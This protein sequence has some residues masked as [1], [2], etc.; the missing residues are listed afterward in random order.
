MIVAAVKMKGREEKRREILQTIRDITDQVRKS[1][2]CLGADCYQDISDKNVF[3]HVQQWQ[4]RKHLDNHMHSKLFSALL[5]IKSILAEP[6]Q[7]EHLHPSS[8]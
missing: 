6:P 7:I 5:G 8:E 2:G 4:S 3:Y 1:E